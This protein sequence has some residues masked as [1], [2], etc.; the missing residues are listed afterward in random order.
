[1]NI[2]VETKERYPWRVPK[3]GWIL[4][5]AWPPACPVDMLMPHHQLPLVRGPAPAIWAGSWPGRA[6][7]PEG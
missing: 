3:M 5:T 6:A 4:T 2:D 7:R 1:M